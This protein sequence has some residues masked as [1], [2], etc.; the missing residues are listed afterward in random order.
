MSVTCDIAY[1]ASVARRLS[2]C[3]LLLA[4]RKWR[5]TRY[6]A[7][8]KQREMQSRKVTLTKAFFRCYMALFSTVLTLHVELLAFSFHSARY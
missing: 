1:A 7:S 5:N 2:S 4:Q 6:D 8:A 3:R